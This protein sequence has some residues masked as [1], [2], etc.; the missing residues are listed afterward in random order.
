MGSLHD[1]AM[2]A[3]APGGPEVLVRQAMEQNPPGA[4]EVLVRHT[5]IGLNF[6]DCYYRSGLYAWPET[7]LVPGGEAAGVVEA[8]GAGVGGFAVGD[9]VAYTTPTGAYRRLR[10]IAADR[11][12]RLPAAIGDVLAAS[13]MLKGLT[14]EYLVTSSFRVEAGQTVLVHAAAGGVGLLLGQ[15]VAALGA[16][17]IGTVGGPE[18][19]A[20]AAAHGYAQ[21]IDYTAGDFADAVRDLTGGAGCHV[22]YDSVGAST[23]RGSLRCLRRRGTYVNF[24]Q[25]SGPI[26]GFRL[27]DL[28]AGGSLAAIRPVLFDYIAERA[29]LEARAAHLFGMIE[30]GALKVDAITTRPLGEAA[31]AHADLEARRTTGATVFLPD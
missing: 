14:A 19:A 25:S 29:D 5:A 13:V 12:V 16:T 15:W 27:A 30:S 31:A 10:R 9:R 11:L 17:A 21:V 22:V 8:V 6:I 1:E 28:A 18:K 20:I 2:I 7:P 3:R 23:W 4:G 24:G 26:E